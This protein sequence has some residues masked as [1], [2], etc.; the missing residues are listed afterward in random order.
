MLSIC[1]PTFNRKNSLKEMLDE[2]LDEA[3]KLNIKIIVS[4]NCS[5]DGTQDYLESVKKTYSNVKIILNSENKGLDFNMLNV[6]KNSSSKY[7][8]W[9]GDDDLLP[10]D[11]LQIVLNKI[12]EYGD[13]DLMV[14]NGLAEDSLVKHM[15]INNDVIIEDA[16]EF[17]RNYEDKLTFGFTIVR[18]YVEEY[19]Q[20]IEKYMGCLHAYSLYIAEYLMTNFQKNGVNKICLLSDNI[21]TRR[22]FEKSYS[23]RLLDL[24]F[25]DMPIQKGL[26]PPFYDEC[27]VKRKIEYQKEITRLRTLYQYRKLGIN[28]MTMNKYMNSLDKWSYKFNILISCLVPIAVL[29]FLKRIYKGIRR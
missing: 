15:Q 22:N 24:M 16:R 10:K 14:L 27:L 11:K 20:R 7:S 1:I 17:F 5:S 18:N 29:D 25:I 23:A 19:E 26:Y 21:I 13:F 2:I 4:D 28:F 3:K 9:I 8:L 12:K 6:L